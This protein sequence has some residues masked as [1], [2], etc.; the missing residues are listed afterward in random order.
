MG[1]TG[2]GPNIQTVAATQ[3]ATGSSTRNQY[4]VPLPGPCL[5]RSSLG[6]LFHVSLADE[7]RIGAMP[8][9]FQLH[10]SHL[11]LKPEPHRDD[12]SGEPPIL[13]EVRMIPIDDL[14]SLASSTHR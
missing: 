2:C 4:T 5:P 9:V 6:H 12:L 1:R 14:Y 11:T 13:L 3:S 7:A 8:T 10:F